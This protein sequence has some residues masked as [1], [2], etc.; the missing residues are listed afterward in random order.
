MWRRRS[1]IWRGPLGRAMRKH[2]WRYAVYQ[3]LFT[4][5][6]FLRYRR[7]WSRWAGGKWIQEQQ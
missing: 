7:V 2:H 5:R 6:E 1:R 4:H 3:R